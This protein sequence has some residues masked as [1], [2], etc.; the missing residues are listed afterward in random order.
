MAF[1]SHYDDGIYR[2]LKQQLQHSQHHDTTTSSSSNPS[3]SPYSPSHDSNNNDS[4]YTLTKTGQPYTTS[5]KI[6]FIRKSDNIPISPFHDIPLLYSSP[7]S[8]S[9]SSGSKI[10]NMIIE[11]PRWTTAKFEVSRSLPL[12]PIIQDSLSSTPTKPRFVH[13]LFPYKGYIWNYGALPQTWESPH[14]SH[15]DTGE[16]GDNDPIDAVEIGSKV[17]YTGEVKRV[18]VLGVLG[19]ID[20][21]ET[22]WKVMCVDVRDK[23]AGKVDDIGDVEREC[24]GLLEAT[25][26]WFKWYGVPEGRKANRYAMGGRW[27]GREYAEGVIGECE[28][29]WKKLVRGEVEG[30]GDIALKNT[31]LR[32]TPGYVEPESVKLPPN[33]DLPP[34]E[35]DQD[36]EEVAYV[37]RNESD[38]DDGD[39]D[40][41]S[42]EDE[43]EMVD[44]TDDEDWDDL[45]KDAALGDMKTLN[46]NLKYW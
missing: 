17:G 43:C 38:D 29:F 36:L 20:S 31:T 26:D 4:E 11:I 15:P 40:S 3:S 2:A 30:S 41:D 39:N 8:S 42:N 22:D 24:P 46:I 19:L 9:S 34:A 13:N 45:T 37:D 35:V 1:L 12:N 6:Y 16:K 28:G 27:M 33:E 5:H 10:Y 25:R 23:L 7:P 21:G 18:K 14:F 44:L 32:G